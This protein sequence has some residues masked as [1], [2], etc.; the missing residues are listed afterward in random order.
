MKKRIACLLVLSAT[1]LLLPKAG[2]CIPTLQLYIEDGFYDHT[3]ESWFTISSDFELTV[4]ATESTPDAILCVALTG[5]LA[6]EIYG[7]GTPNELVIVIDGVSYY[8]EDFV[9]G[10]PPLATTTDQNPGGDD[11]AP[12]GVYPGYYLEV[13]PVAITDPD[14]IFD[15]QPLFPDETIVDPET[16]NGY[17]YVFDID[18][19][20]AGVH[21]DLYT[22]NP[23]GTIDDF[24]PFSHDAGTVVPEPATLLL[25]GSGLMILPITRYLTRKRIQR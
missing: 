18:D 15:T 12:H 5:E 10:Y 22:L 4:F 13:S 9:F 7:N 17:S 14:Q 19:A 8:E 24:A 21:F 20:L 2:F 3:D 1:V 25:L 23:D 16:K 11:L 6:G